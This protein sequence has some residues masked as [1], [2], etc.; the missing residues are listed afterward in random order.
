MSSNP[1]G[2]VD[3]A[4]AKVNPVLEPEVT[5]IAPQI[6]TETVSRWW[7]IAAVV[8]AAGPA[9]I[10]AVAMAVRRPLIFFDGDQAEAELVVIRAGHFAQLTG[11]GERFGWSH[12]GP[13]WLYALSFIYRPLGGQ[14]WGI[15]VANM[16]LNALTVA[17]IV[18]VIWRKWGPPMA[19]F[20]AV[21][22]LAYVGVMG[23]QLLRDIWPPDVLMLT[24]LLLLLLS[25]AGAAG[26]NAA[27]VGAFILG[28]YAAQLHLGTAPTVAAVVAAAVGL[29]IAYRYRNLRA[30]SSR[31]ANVAR[32]PWDRLLV[33]GGLI[34]LVLMWVPPAI[35]ELTGHPGNLTVLW[36]FFAANYPKHPYLQAVSA[37]GRLVM[38]LE[39]PRLFIADISR[40]SAPFIAIG[41]AFVALSLALAAMA[42]RVGDRFAQSIGAI[43][44]VAALAVTIS[45]RDVE[46]PV[47]AYLLIWATCLPLMLLIGWIGLATK[48]PQVRVRIPRVVR[49]R[50]V[51][52]LAAA[53]GVLSLISVVALL[54]LPAYP[55]AAPDTRAAWILTSAALDG[56][57]K[58][59]VLVD[60]STTDTWVV[61]TGV[62]L[63]LEKEGRPARV[64]DNWV[65]VFGRQARMD[66]SERYV[67]AFVDLL[68][69]P[70]YAAQHPGA[71]L[72]GSTQAHSLF[73][74]QAP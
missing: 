68:D 28:S 70:A 32:T 55:N 56:Q 42:T 36:Q 19:L 49:A 60:I 23:E 57:T 59:P 72:I 29:R 21:V 1:A 43:V 8:L 4:A 47:Y 58:Q 16:F 20:S 6:E 63:Q 69:A 73:L 53:L 66:G 10:A 39:W 11:I 41:V 54:A 17:L 46:G 30:G 3:Q 67:L 13:A 12:P 18:A 15:V 24:M 65:Y 22:V 26:S 37:L 48:L 62:A 34:V 40:L 14:S 5:R 27:L 61:A 74:T 9:T 7:G 33:L 2:K 51:L 71:Q 64:R 52:V 50:G 38:P 25:A 35:D 44:A 45:V 31:D